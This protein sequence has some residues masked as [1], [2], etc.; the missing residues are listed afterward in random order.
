MKKIKNIL[1][2]AILYF[3][4]L[5]TTNSFAAEEFTLSKEYLTL[6]PSV[7]YTLTC[8][9]DVSSCDY[10]ILNETCVDRN[11][12]YIENDIGMFLNFENNLIYIEP[13]INW[14]I[15]NNEAT[16]KLSV[17]S[18]NNETK[19]CIIH[20]PS[21]KRLL[22]VDDLY[23]PFSNNKV[24][25][26]INLK[27]KID[28]DSNYI[29]YTN[30]N[31]H[32]DTFDYNYFFVMV[33]ENEVLKKIDD[34]TFEIQKIGNYIYKIGNNG[35]SYGSYNGSIFEFKSP[36]KMFVN[37]NEV[38]SIELNNDY[39]VML[40]EDE[41]LIDVNSNWIIEDNNIV[42][43]MDNTKQ[44]SCW[45]PNAY[46]FF[47]KNAGTTKIVVKSAYDNHIIEKEIEVINPVKKISLDKKSL[48]LKIG[49]T[50]NLT[51]TVTPTDATYKELTWT[52]SNEKVATVDENGKITAISNGLAVISAVGHGDVEERCIVKVVN[53]VK[54]ITFDKNTL[55]LNM[56]ETY[57]L[58]ATVTATDESYK[59]LTWT[60]SNENVATVD[61]NGKITAVNS[62]LAIITAVGY[63]DVEE[64]CI[65][66]VINPVKKI[67]FDKT[68]LELKKDETYNLI[69]TVTATDEKYKSLT[70]SSSNEKVATVDENGKITAIDS[71]LAVISAV[72]Y[73]DVEERCIVLVKDDKPNNIIITTLPVT[74]NIKFAK[75][76]LFNSIATEENFPILAYEGYGIKL[77]SSSGEE[78]AND[79]I[80]G[81]KDII[82]VYDANDIITTYN[83]VVK[84]D[85]SGDGN[86]RIYDSFQILKDVLTNKELDE[87]DTEVR[88][89]NGDGKVAIY[90]AFQYLKEAILQ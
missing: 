83:V 25:A 43:F 60:S 2:I 82:S 80:L 17:T 90:D 19:D 4:L 38:F 55:E 21:V 30:T 28:V 67:S 56:S 6:L 36:E 24:G 54:K 40:P 61:E 1:L 35:G 77:Y 71:G 8:S 46:T 12:N 3:A 20:I 86:V 79:S 41:T 7:E 33:D 44:S 75:N 81:S 85:I 22:G 13:Y 18:V 76:T 32:I 39:K 50:H 37:K 26:T 63:G 23:E 27:P 52:S 9:D 10:T 84:G 78:K 74:S 11:G 14:Y 57:D 16:I 69:A 59:T 65:V 62:G 34:Y 42:L 53:P 70:W 68:S 66:K 15:G 49:E 58:V 87:V 72:G 29:Y 48:E 31:E 73:G 64:K 51:A 89:Y 47:A 45:G 5:A 88:D